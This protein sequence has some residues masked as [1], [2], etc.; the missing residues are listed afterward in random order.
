MAGGQASACPPHFPSL[1][2]L[3][4]LNG[5]I[6]LNSDYQL[7]T[8]SGGAAGVVVGHVFLLSTVTALKC[9][10]DRTARVEC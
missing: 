8:T 6:A 9:A 2:G 7:F 5:K 4:Q 10:L 3:W 1:Y